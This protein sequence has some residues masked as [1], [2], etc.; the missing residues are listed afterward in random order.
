VVDHSRGLLLGSLNWLP[1]IYVV[2]SGDLPCQVTP[3]NKKRVELP[4]NRSRLT[5]CIES[6]LCRCPL[7]D[8]EQPTPPLDTEESPMCRGVANLTHPVATPETPLITR[9]PRLGIQLRRCTCK[10]SNQISHF[11]PTKSKNNERLS[12]QAKIMQNKRKIMQCTSKM[13][14]IDLG[15]PTPAGPETPDFQSSNSPSRASHHITFMQKHRFLGI[16]AYLAP[17]LSPHSIRSHQA[18]DKIRGQLRGHI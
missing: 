5:M 14:N 17:L 11:Q 4:M 6:A 7:Q 1:T 13:T 16:R 8:P 2:R 10:G 18:I 3:R 12:R 9:K 15:N